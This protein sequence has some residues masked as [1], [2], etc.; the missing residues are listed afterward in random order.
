MGL[1]YTES[2]SQM[3]R[4]DTIVHVLKYNTNRSLQTDLSALK[5]TWLCENMPP[6]NLHV[7]MKP[8]IA[9]AHV[10]TF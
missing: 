3:N 4:N 2:N 7:A 9:R 1:V 5:Q 8:C 10:Y 6:I